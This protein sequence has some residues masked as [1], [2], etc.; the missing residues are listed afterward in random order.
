[1]VLAVVFAAAW[2]AAYVNAF[3][4]M[5]GI[6]GISVAQTLIAGCALGWLAHEESASGV[7]ALSLAVA[8]AA[9]GFA[10]FNVMN[11]SI[12][13]GDVGSYFL[14]TWLALTLVLVVAEG[15]SLVVALG[16]FVLYLLDTATTLVKRF[17]RGV[18]LFDAH[19]EHAY[20]QLVEHGWAHTQ[21]A[22]LAAGVIGLDSVVLIVSNGQ[23]WWWQA[24]AMGLALLVAG[25]FVVLP[26]A[27]ATRS[28]PSV[29]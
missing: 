21:V 19:R 10:P 12:F 29:A 26:A 22:L 17:R 5:D 18:R 28:G 16:P 27:L 9:I 3:N 25:L 2:C 6:N 8:G 15:T 24:V 11:A 1:V 14:G 20:Q 13:L 23:A 4:F 7:V